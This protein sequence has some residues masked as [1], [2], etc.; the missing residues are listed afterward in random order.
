MVARLR[1]APVGETMFPPRAPF[2]WVRLSSRGPQVT[3]CAE[4][5]EWGNLPVS[6]GGENRS[7]F[8]ASPS[9]AHAL[10]EPGPVIGR[11]CTKRRYR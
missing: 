11:F 4:E 10:R 9:P 5:I 6:P 3:A 7:V 8:S 1:L 2:F